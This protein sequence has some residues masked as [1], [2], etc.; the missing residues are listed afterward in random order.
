MIGGKPLRGSRGPLRFIILAATGEDIRHCTACEC[1]CVDDTLQARFDLPVWEVFKAAC[2]NDEAALTNQT[3]WVLAGARPADA[4]CKNGLN[5][6]AVAQVLCREARLR[7]LA[8]ADRQV[9]IV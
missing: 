2:N 6:V 8:P 4:R 7:G 5:L 1:C 9:H 3:I